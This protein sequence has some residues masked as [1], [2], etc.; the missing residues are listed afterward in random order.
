MKKIIYIILVFLVNSNIFAQTGWTV[1][2]TGTNKPMRDIYFV[3]ANTGWA[4]GDSVIVKSTNGGVNWVQQNFYYPGG[5]L[6]LAVKFLNQNTGY[7]GGGKFTSEY[8]HAQYL[9]KTT[10]GGNNWNLI[11]NNTYFG[12]INNILIINE[13]IVYLTLS[14]WVEM[15]ALGG[16]YKSTDGGLNFNQ[17]YAGG[18]IS[19]LSFINENTGWTIC[20]ATSDII[21]YKSSKVLKTSNGGANWTVQYRDSGQY[22]ATINTVQFINEYTGYAI[23]YKYY[24]KTVFYKTTNGGTNWDTIIFNH[25]RNYSLFFLNPNTGWISGWCSTDSSSIYYT[26]NGGSN[27]QKQFK[28]YTYSVS[29]LNFINS[30]YGWAVLGYN[31]SNILRTTTGGV[32]FVNNI[33]SEIPEK[34]SLSQNYPNPFNPSTNLKYQIKDSRFVTLKVYDITGKEITTLVNEKQSPGT[35]EVK[36]EAGDL[37]SGVY[38]YKLTTEDYSE[39]RKMILLK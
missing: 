7:A 31:S 12:W 20:N 15:N 32:V 21:N 6:L 10:N 23:G 39:T 19:S 22:S 30:L 5:A 37:P 8:S 33:S 24:D 17:C 27:W 9:F 11:W 13:N 36:F 14:G 4:V 2:S 16:F 35:Y 18:S 25:N 26:I 29:R 38:F 3:D 1:H 28:N 34:Y